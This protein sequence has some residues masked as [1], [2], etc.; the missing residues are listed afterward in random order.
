M[1]QIQVFLHTEE[2]YRGTTGEKSELKTG[3]FLSSRPNREARIRFTLLTETTKNK[4]EKKYINWARGT[5]SKIVL[6][7]RYCL[8]GNE[9]K[10]PRN[11]KQMR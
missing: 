10:L 2:N 9:G 4:S 5:L 8:S 7:S 1:P 11:R 6:I 3:G